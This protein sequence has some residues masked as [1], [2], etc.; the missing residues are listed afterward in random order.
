MSDADLVLDVK[1]GSGP[2]EVR[3]E[4]RELLAVIAEAVADPRI[5]VQKM[6]RLLEMHSKIVAEQRRV[7]FHEALARLQAKCPQVNKDGRI[8]VKGTERSRYARLETID[9]VIRPLL[10]AEDFALSFDTHTKDDGKHFLITATLSRHG[11]SEV[12]EMLLPLDASDYR[13]VV[14]STGSTFA[15]GRRQLTKAHLNIIEKDE[16]DDGQGGNRPITASQ[17]ADLHSLME[18]VKADKGRFLVYMGVGD[19]TDILSR[20]YRKAVAALEAK[21]RGKGGG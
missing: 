7:E 1:P 9:V 16:D 12:K 10:A 20:D 6:E 21:R 5:D 14:Q 18:E 3:R 2:I 13:S 11:H 8:I 15:Y 17:A 4:P 19:L